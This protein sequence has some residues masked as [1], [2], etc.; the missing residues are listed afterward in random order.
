MDQNSCTSNKRHERNSN[1]IRICDLPDPIL[2]LILSSLPIK[3]AIGTSVLSKRWEH[4]W[5]GI[6]KIS[7]KE[8]GTWEKRRQF[9]VFVTK[10]LEVFDCTNLENLLTFRVGGHASEVN[11]WLSGFINPKIQEL[12]LC[13]DGTNESEKPLTFPDHLFTCSTL[14]TFGLRLRNVFKLPSSIYFKSLKTLCLVDVTLPDRSSTEQLIAGCPALEQLTLMD[15]N[16][17]NVETLCIFSDVLQKLEI[18]EP[19][20]YDV[21]AREDEDED[22][23]DDMGGQDEQNCCNIVI[24]GTNLKVFSYTGAV[25]SEI[26]FH[27]PAS[28]IDA[29]IHVQHRYSKCMDNFDWEPAAGSY[30]VDLLK[31]LQDVEKL[32]VSFVSLMALSR[33]LSWERLP[34]FSNLVEL[35]V[36]STIISLTCEGLI[37]IIQ[38]SPCLQVVHF[39]KGVYMLKYRSYCG[40]IMDPVPVLS[41]TQLRRIVIKHYSWDK[42]DA[43]KTLLQ[44]LPVLETLHISCSG[45]G[46]SPTGSERLDNLC[47]KIKSLPRR[48]KDCEIVL[49][50]MK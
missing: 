33:A 36:V 8:E 40:Y 15:I 21:L 32:S 39:D 49:K 42:F 30:V 44:A 31:D 19:V 17:V 29:S 20:E 11:E 16:W 4:L 37:A 25:T 41:R 38:K 18:I 9:I 7:L 10:L 27:S 45:D 23:D 46:N 50:Y 2:Q 35:H 28:V 13:L 14:T 26:S 12:I 6:S 24:S 5:M 34:L 3:D 43:V 1:S 47:Q 48:S 22:E